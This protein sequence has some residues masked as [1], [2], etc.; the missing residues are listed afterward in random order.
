MEL[1]VA[2]LHR[3]GAEFL[4]NW[5][6]A[7]PA[8]MHP[9]S[10]TPIDLFLSDMLCYRWP[11]APGL[12]VSCVLGVAKEPRLGKCTAHKKGLSLLNLPLAVWDQTTR[13]TACGPLTGDH[14]RKYPL[15][16]HRQRIIGKGKAR[17]SKAEGTVVRNQR[18]YSSWSTGTVFFLLI[19][20]SSLP[21]VFQTVQRVNKHIRS[22]WAAGWCDGESKS[23]GFEWFHL[24]FLSCHFL[25]LKMW[26][27]LT[28]SVSLSVKWEYNL[29]LLLFYED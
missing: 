12:Y 3:W 10:R 7:Q 11:W 6:R 17:W 20:G 1:P 21:P 16:C 23:L 5:G 8:W 9:T 29:S 14:V 22:T 24:K 13:F 26:Q 15:K 25:N 19:G 18:K 27:F 2:G 28:S 4:Q